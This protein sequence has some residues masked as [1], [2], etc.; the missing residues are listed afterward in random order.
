MEPDKKSNGAMIGLVI[1]IILLLVGGIYV[2]QSNTKVSVPSETVTS[3]DSAELNTLEAS[4]QTIDT[5][6]GVDVNTVQ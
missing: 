6:V 1:I 4:L 2:W 5:N 3:E